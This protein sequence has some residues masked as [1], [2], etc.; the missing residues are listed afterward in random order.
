MTARPSGR[1][2]T[3]SLVSGIVS[4]KP[5]GVACAKA[6]YHKC[7]FSARPRQNLNGRRK[8]SSDHLP[9]WV[10]CCRGVVKAACVSL[11]GP[12]IQRFRRNPQLHDEYHAQRNRSTPFA[13]QAKG[14]GAEKRSCEVSA[15][16]PR[17]Y[18]PGP[19]SGNDQDSPPACAALPF[20]P[21]RKSF[22]DAGFAR[23]SVRR[24][25]R[26]GQHSSPEARPEDGN[27]NN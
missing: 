1:I 7:A 20:P 9:G 19:T 16:T 27:P 14:Y 24:A 3:L 11:D 10:G 8:P 6:H 22:H 18:G 17:D 23:A 12:A 2:I 4:T 15:R 25:T 5:A 13:R 26:Q 21:A